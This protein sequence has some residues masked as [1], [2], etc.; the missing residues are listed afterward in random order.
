M[1]LTDLIRSMKST[2]KYI[3]DG[4]C[5]PEDFWWKILPYWIA[6]V[7]QAQSIEDAK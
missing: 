2:L 1:D 5:Y 7:E 3:E 4:N 6:E